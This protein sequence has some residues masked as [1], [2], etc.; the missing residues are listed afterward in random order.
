MKY[1]KTK[2]KKMK[3]LLLLLSIVLVF[4]CKEEKKN[5]PTNFDFGKIEGTVYSNDFFKFKISS[6]PDWYVLSQEQLDNVIEDGVD[7][8]ADNSG[9]TTFKRE[10]EASKVNL[11][12]LFGVYQ[13]ELGTT[14]DFNPSLAMNAEN[15]KDFPEIVTIEDYLVQAKIMMQQTGM[16]L[17][18]MEE[19]KRVKLGSQ[20]FI[21][22]ILENNT[23]EQ[24]IKQEFYS[25]LINNFALNIIV[26]YV[27]EEDKEELQKMLSTIKFYK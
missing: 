10:V 1:W 15:L 19:D 11:A 22:I 3:K 6:N 7:Y 5:M 27:E 20:E 2:P 9:D 17:R 18:F 4:G 16:T 24:P 26:S 13:S 8:I 25:T 14:Y 23:F 12:N 21:G